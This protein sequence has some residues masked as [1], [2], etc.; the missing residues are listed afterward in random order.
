VISGDCR[1]YCNERIRCGGV[2]GDNFSLAEGMVDAVSITG[3]VLADFGLGA[4][5]QGGV[6]TVL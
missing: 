4:G 5:K 2:L 3:E 6:T 1:E